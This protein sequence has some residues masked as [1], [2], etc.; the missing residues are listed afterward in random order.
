ML[1]GQK[2]NANNWPLY[3]TLARETKNLGGIA[4]YAHGGYAQA[5][6]GDFVRRNVS[7]VE[8]LQFGTYRGIE[9]ADWYHI[10]NISYRFP[11]LGGKRLPRLPYI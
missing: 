10:L 5:I 1:K 3:S 2:T 6:Y 4:I 11:C 8:M 7:A 9:L